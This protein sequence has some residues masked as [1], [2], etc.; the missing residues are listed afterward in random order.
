MVKGERNDACQPGDFPTIEPARFRQ[1]RQQDRLRPDAD[2]LDAFQALLLF[3]RPDFEQ[4]GAPRH[5]GR[6]GFLFPWAD[7]SSRHWRKALP[8]FRE[9]TGQTI[10]LLASREFFRDQGFLRCF[11]AHPVP[12]LRH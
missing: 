5:P 2:A 10:F 1:R 11:L 3:D 8:S 4:L 6:Q 7:A 12:R 9:K